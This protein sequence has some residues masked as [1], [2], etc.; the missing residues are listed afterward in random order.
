MSETADYNPGHWKGHDFGAARKKYDAHVGR[1][2]GDAVA[3]GKKAAD[4]A[5]DM[6]KTKSK[7]PLA[8]LCDVTGSMGKWP[9]TIFSKLPYLEIE[10]KEYLGDD[11]EISFCA[12][13]DVYSDNYPL[14]VRKFSKGTDLKIQLEAL[15]IEG[16]GGGQVKESP[17]VAALYYARNVEMPLASKPICIIITDESLYDAVSKEDAKRHA[18]VDLEKRIPTKDIFDELKRR[19][20]VYLVRK[21]YQTMSGDAISSTDK[22]IVKEWLRYVDED[23][24][25]TLP[26]EERVLDIIFGILAKE[27]DKVDYFRDELKDRQLKDKGGAKKVEV[28]LK[29]LETIHKEVGAGI[30][31]DRKLLKS[32]RSV[33]KGSG[34]GKKTKS[35][36]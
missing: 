17:E 5:P 29:A 10:G 13:G 34:G 21:P 19:Y 23:H 28:A 35:L 8:I 36:L 6:I 30:D 27:T 25:V 16:G 26:N 3:T 11:L 1:S 15:V 24:I 7:A 32:G 2:Y 18:K 12:F 14:Q 33:T 31:P 20:A 4:M 9:A 22:G